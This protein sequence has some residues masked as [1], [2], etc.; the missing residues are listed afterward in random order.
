M[1]QTNSTPPTLTALAAGLAL[2]AITS[3]APAEPADLNFDPH[4]ASGDGGLDESDAQ[5]LVDAA[6]L[7]DDAQVEA[8]GVTLTAKGDA[9]A[10]DVKFDPAQSY[11]G[12]VLPAPDG[13]WDLSQRHIIA[14]DVT[15]TGTGPMTVGMRIDNEGGDE[16]TANRI[17]KVEDIQ[18]GE[19]RTVSIRL[20][21]TPWRLVPPIDLVGMHQAPG[22]SKL[23]TTAITR[24]LVYSREPR[25]D[26][27]FEIRNIRTVG[28]MV[29]VDSE[30]F[31]PFVDRFGQFAHREFEGKIT[32]DEQLR[33]IGDA[34]LAHTPTKPETWS[35][36]GGWA[37]GPQ[38]EATGEFRTAKHEGKWYLVDPEGFLFWS[39]G[40]TS[41]HHGYSETGV[42]GREDYFAELPPRDGEIGDAHSTSSWAPHGYYH[43]KRPFDTINFYVAN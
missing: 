43:D 18:P 42:P 31:L 15:N 11:P 33:E 16:S 1:I 13:V 41:I 30:T 17:D 29:D 28:T 5:T 34:E 32:S 20:Y 38:L 14:M 35:K 24:L 22:L 40:V 27:S 36:F 37:D 3:H 7:A 26:Q 4:I 39:H 19:T 2:L 6:S 25:T 21:S 8:R 23:D 12:F 10:V 9:L